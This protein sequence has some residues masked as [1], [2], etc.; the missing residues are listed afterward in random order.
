MKRLLHI[1]VWAL[2]SCIFSIATRAEEFQFKVT[3]NTGTFKLLFKNYRV[4]VDADITLFGSEPS[5]DTMTDQAVSDI[6][7]LHDENILMCVDSERNPLAGVCCKN[8]G[9][10]CSIYYVDDLLHKLVN[11][12]SDV[13][14]SNFYDS[15]VKFVHYY[16]EQ[17][18]MGNKMPKEQSQKPQPSK[19]GRIASANVQDLITELFGI[20]PMSELIPSADT[21]LEICDELGFDDVS[22]DSGTVKIE[23]VDDPQTG[24]AFEFK[25]CDI[26]PNAAVMKYEPFNNNDYDEYLVSHVFYWKDGGNKSLRLENIKKRNEFATFIYNSLLKLAPALLGD[27]ESARTFTK[28]GQV[29]LKCKDS[30]NEVTVELI[31]DSR[32][33]FM[34]DKIKRR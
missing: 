18:L 25:D 21:I 6:I 32:F 28:E 34:E 10:Y 20:F 31:V 22:E 7:L 8:D 19:G 5:H 1:L 30:S 26:I 12:V 13:P 11:V 17:N 15:Y 3:N 33:K 29:F 4:K 16:M 23:F 24:L 14:D 2:F 27:Y 9:K